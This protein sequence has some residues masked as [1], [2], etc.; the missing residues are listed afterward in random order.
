MLPRTPV[1]RANGSMWYPAKSREGF[2]D[3]VASPVIRPTL[4]PKQPNDTG[5]NKK[6]NTKTT[7]TTTTTTTN[8]QDFVIGMGS[9]T[10][11]LRVG[12]PYLISLANAPEL[13]FISIPANKVFRVSAVIS[14]DSFSAF[15]AFFSKLIALHFIS[16]EMAR[17]G[18]G[19][20]T[21]FSSLGFKSI[22]SLAV[23]TSN[24]ITIPFPEFLGK[25]ASMINQLFTRCPDGFLAPLIKS[26][27]MIELMGDN[28]GGNFTE[29]PE[30]EI[31][32]FALEMNKMNHI[33]SDHAMN[34]FFEEMRKKMESTKCS[35]VE[36]YDMIFKSNSDTQAPVKKRSKDRDGRETFE[37]M[38][39]TTR[40]VEAVSEY[41]PMWAKY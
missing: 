5:N 39:I 25:A 27:I 11:A 38:P 2:A 8:P 21:R 6:T 18:L 10:L 7:T 35:D 4:P 29:I 14:L 31:E 17:K 36:I 16:P 24:T 15:N 23:R 20:D 9:S 40:V 3:K 30:S 12:T 22:L 34:A 32:A 37:G 33:Y 26:G 28:N 1:Y 13:K 41:I 19:M